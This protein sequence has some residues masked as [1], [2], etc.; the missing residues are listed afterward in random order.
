MKSSQQKKGSD[1]FYL[2]G[3]SDSEARGAEKCDGWGK[4]WGSV[5][6]NLFID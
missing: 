5:L 6:I 1:L 2:G 4:C 3:L